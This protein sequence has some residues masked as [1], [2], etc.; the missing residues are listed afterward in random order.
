MNNKNV[1]YLHVKKGTNNVFYVG[2]GTNRR[3]AYQTK[4]RNQH[5]QRVVSKYGYEV[6]II[7]QGLS[8]EDACI[9]EKELISAFGRND[10]NSEGQLVNKTDGGEGSPGFIPSKSF[11]KILSKTWGRKHTEEEK[12]SISKSLKRFYKDNPEI[13]NGKNNSFYGK[14]H[15]KE[16]IEKMKANRTPAVGERHGRSK[17]S[18]ETAKEIKDLTKRDEFLY[19][20]IADI[21]G[22]PYNVVSGI[23]RGH[24]W[25]H[26]N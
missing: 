20:D 11:L 26:L 22:I 2:I 7:N 18:E 19:R 21:Y 8:R 9:V 1:V 25:K 10:L 3:R 5:W 24:T 17:I 12:D 23:G 15:T 14:K 16:S 4:S 13:L 6:R